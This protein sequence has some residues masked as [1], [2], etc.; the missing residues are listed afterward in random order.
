MRI[1]LRILLLILA[2]PFV[3]GPEELRVSAQTNYPVYLPLVSKAI[4]PERLGPYLS[5][6]AIGFAIDP[7]NSA[8]V[9]AG[10]HGGGVYKTVNGGADW[11]PASLGLPTGAQIQ[12]M[13]IDPR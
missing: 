2:L 10:T 6:A 8:V 5:P 13:A 4:P 3:F 12:S 9:Y 11:T 1:S 7:S